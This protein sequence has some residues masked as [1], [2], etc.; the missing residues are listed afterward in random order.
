[1]STL[2]GKILPQVIPVQ[3]RANRQSVARI[4]ALSLLLLAIFAMYGLVI[5]PW[6]LNWGA[7]TAEMAGPWPGDELTANPAYTATRVVTV[8]APASAVWPWI[9][10]M[11]QGRGGLYSYEVLENLIGC[12]LHNADRIHPEWQDL[13]VGDAVRFIPEGFQGMADT[14]KWTVLAIEPNR[15]LVL[16]GWA[17]WILDPVDAQ[18]TRMI[19]RERP[20][21]AVLP[22]EPFDFIMTR[23]MMLGIKER[24]EGGQGSWAADTTQVALWVIAAIIGISAAIGTLVRAAWQRSLVVTG[25]AGAVLLCLL[26]VQPPLWLGMGLNAV[27]L[28]ALLWAYQ[29][30]MRRAM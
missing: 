17:A 2:T 23:R 4:V 8:N 25:L 1:M 24:A 15:A 28:G 18:T 29:T 27:I 3:R 21:V 7:T 16:D 14:P 30:P 10:Q 9:V 11:G 12:D 19:Q 20:A 5:R 13:K 6:F 22:L 26:F